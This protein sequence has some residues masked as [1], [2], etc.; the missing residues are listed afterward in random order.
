MRAWG[1]QGESGSDGAGYNFKPSGLISIAGVLYMAI[2][3]QK[4]GTLASGWVQSAG[5]CQIIKSSDHGVTWTPVP[6]GNSQPYAAP[7]FANPRFGA[8]SFVQYGQ[9]Y[10]GNTV[11]NSDLYVYAISPDGVWNNGNYLTLGRCLLSNLPNLNGADW[12]FYRGGNGMDSTRW[13][14]DIN[15]AVQILYKTRSVGMTAMQY[16]PYCQ[17]YLMIEWFYPTLVSSTNNDTTQTT[18]EVYDSPAPW[19]PWRFVQS[20][21]FTPSGLYNP[22]VLHK[23][24][25]TDNGQTLR[26]ITAG[27]YNSQN[28]ATGDYQL[29]LLSATINN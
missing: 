9:N 4:Y 26:L 20:I 7:M 11:H 24:M 17:R 5:T 14:S 29:T 23:S 10:A 22:A 13:V 25:A 1:L 12:E 18:W 19:G 15:S 2:S 27:N 3:R 28:A 16:L 21:N 6:P 8:P